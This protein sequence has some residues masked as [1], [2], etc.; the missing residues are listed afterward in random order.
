MSH[1][2]TTAWHHSKHIT[3]S[4]HNKHSTPT[5]SEVA[6]PRVG[7][8]APPGRHHPPVPSEARTRWTPHPRSHRG[9]PH[10]LHPHMVFTFA[11]SKVQR[12]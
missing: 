9:G 7:G 10:N 8:L 2:V 5:F 6:H 3:G 12:T 4:H 11:K 1:Q